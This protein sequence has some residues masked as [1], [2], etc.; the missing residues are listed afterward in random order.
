MT[1]VSEV[2]GTEIGCKP[3]A[4]SITGNAATAT[5]AS[6]CSGNA[7][8]ATKLETVRTLWGQSFD[9]SKNISGNISNTGNI[10]PS[11]TKTSDLGSNALSYR[12]VYTTWVGA[13]GNTKLALGGSNAT[14]LTIDTNG[15]VGIGTSSPTSK[16]HVAG[17]GYFTGDTSSAANIIAGGYVKGETIK[18][19]SGC[20]L[21]YDSTQ[22][23]VKFVFS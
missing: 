21:E 1:P 17:S 7:G 13:P 10:I 12:Y 19:S 3:I 8:T 15:N 14:H 22:K 2:S 4:T 16:L 11:V 9:G 18:V 23:C 6:S 5:I 20:T